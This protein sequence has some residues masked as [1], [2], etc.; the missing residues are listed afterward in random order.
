MQ[1]YCLNLYGY[2]TSKLVT[3]YWEYYAE[4]LYIVMLLLLFKIL[5]SVP[6]NINYYTCVVVL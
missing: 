6:N 1:H 5:D 2:I 4:T 3:V